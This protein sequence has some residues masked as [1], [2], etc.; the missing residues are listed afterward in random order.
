MMMV[1]NHIP[2]GETDKAWLNPGT[3]Q[4]GD[5]S[6]AAA[7]GWTQSSSVWDD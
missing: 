3:M 4:E 2:S 1:S 6:D 7:R 5:G